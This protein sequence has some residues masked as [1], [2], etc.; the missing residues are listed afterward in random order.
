MPL[1][2]S[3]KPLARL[4]SGKEVVPRDSSAGL[5]RDAAGIGEGSHYC[6]L[7]NRPQIEMRRAP[8]ISLLAAAAALQP[9]ARKPTGGR[10]PT[11]ALQPSPLRASGQQRRQR[12]TGWSVHAT[13]RRAKGSIRPE[14]HMAGLGDP[15]MLR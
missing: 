13:S 10:L 2:V 9:A 3:Y 11:R 1:L 7:L 5:R 14:P 12:N 4:M 6:A 15:Q 8:L